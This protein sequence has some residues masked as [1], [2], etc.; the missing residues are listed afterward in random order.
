[1]EGLLDAQNIAQ[2]FWELNPN[3]SKYAD[4]WYRDNIE[5]G[6]ELARQWVIDNRERH[7]RHRR[8]RYRNEERFRINQRRRGERRRCN[9]VGAIGSH[10]PEEWLAKLALYKYHCAYCGRKMK[11]LTKDHL[12]PLSKGGTDFIDN[13]IPACPFC[14]ASKHDRSLL[15]WRNFEYLQLVLENR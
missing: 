12:M 9:Q 6:R 2:R 4:H 8:A 5:L 13:I 3:A 7:N 15:E 1:M 11:R 14:N 10:T